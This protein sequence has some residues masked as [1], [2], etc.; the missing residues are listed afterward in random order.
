MRIMLFGA[1]STLGQWILNEALARGH[2]VTAA[3]PDPSR[4]QEAPGVTLRQGDA[5]SPESVVSLAAGQDV[6]VSALGPGHGGDPCFPVELAGS[7]LAASLQTSLR[8]VIVGGA[9]DPEVAPCLRIIETLDFAATWL[10]INLAYPHAIDALRAAPEEINWTLIQPATAIELG[11][12]TG[13]YRT[14]Q[15]QFLTDEQGLSRISAA[16][17]AVAVI[18]EV[19][20]PRHP[21]QQVTI[22][23]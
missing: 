2:A 11:E 19:E 8:L 15:E 13:R 21:R 7:L 10:G 16:D 6:L 3:S 4:I 12:R 1:N 14:G 20:H 18:D 22:A 17:L 9:S 23:Y 5:L